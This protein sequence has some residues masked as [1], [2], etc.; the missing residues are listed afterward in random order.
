MSLRRKLLLGCLLWLS[1]VTVL[2]LWLNLGV[3]EPGRGETRFR[4]GFLPVT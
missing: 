3:F 2:H 1:T 4:V